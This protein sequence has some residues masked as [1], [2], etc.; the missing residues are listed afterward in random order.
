MTDA[1]TILAIDASSTTLGYVLWQ[2]G[3]VLA[4]GEHR[5]AGAD[6]A[7]RSRSARDIL[8]RLLDR[9]AGVCVVAIEAPVA[10]YA[11]AVIPQARVSGALLSLVAERVGLLWCEVPPAQAK[12]ALTGHGDASKEEMQ[13]AARV[14]G[15]SGE[16]A[17]DA[18]GV[19]KSAEK[20]IRVV[21]V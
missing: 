20:M 10:R 1:P 5:L 7:C 13:A 9:Y 15:V 14:Y 8:E 16:H 21:A 17:A 4:F 11:S 2:A 3:A 6:I 18:L 12:R 19:A